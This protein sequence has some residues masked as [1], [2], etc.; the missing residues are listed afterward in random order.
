M[1]KLT[2]TLGAYPADQLGMILPHEHIFVDLSPIEEENWKHADADAVVKMMAP[3]LNRAKEA[4]VTALV[5]C[6]PVGVG[7]RADILLAVSE[8]AD[9][10]IV[11]PTG[12]YREPWV[13]QWAHKAP[14]EQIRDWMVAEL[15]GEIEDTGVQAGWIKLSAG[16]DGL[17]NTET[18]ILRAAAQAGLETGAL[19]G[20]H[21]IQGRVVKN[22]LNIIEE[23]GYTPERF[24]WIHTQAEED[25]SLHL[26]IARQGAW[27]EYD[28][29]G[30]EPTSDDHFLD[31]I[32][33]VLDA[34]FGKQL[35]LSHDRG[36]FDPAQPGG[37]EAKPF[38]YL[39]NFFLPQLKD[40]G[41]DETTISRL[42]EENPFR[43]F[44]R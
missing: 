15:T 39:S 7:R 34:G 35:L 30:G 42:V 36:W 37:G 23:E 24:L 6:T 12:I 3:E 2:T 44:A 13:P 19:I 5:E 9:F 1:K 28:S 27:L 22:Q 41:I 20:S 33:R 11:V 8:A 10:P 18:K 40:R 17:T 4:G 38:T 21:T 43:A 32:T 14:L 25:F 26:D 29:I 16:D 31:M